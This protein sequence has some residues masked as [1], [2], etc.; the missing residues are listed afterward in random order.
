MG[1]ANLE[2][3]LD[4][5]SD[6]EKEAFNALMDACRTFARG[7]LVENRAFICRSFSFPQES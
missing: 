7:Y 4:L 3:L 1:N 6:E 2:T 5:L